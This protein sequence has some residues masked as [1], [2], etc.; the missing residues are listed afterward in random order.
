MSSTYGNLFRISTFGESHGKA[1]G[2]VVDG[3]PAG[4]KL[5]EADIQAE[6]DRRKPGQSKLTTP[7]KEADTVEILSG[8][9][10]GR[11]TGTPIGMTV[12]NTDQRSH[13]YGDMV[14][15]YR[16]SHADFTY[17]LKYGFRDYRGGGRASARE[18]IGRVAAGAIARKI[19]KEVC[20]TEILA[21]VSQVGSIDADIDP[22]KATFKTIESNLVRC[23]DP[24]AA[25]KMAK[26]IDDAR[27]A[28]DS[29]GGVIQLVI[30]NAPKGVGEPVF[31]RAEA[32]LARAFLSLPA[33]KGFEIGSGFAGTRLRGSEHNDPFVNK[34]GTKTGT[35]AGKSKSAASGFAAIGTETNR[36]GGVQGG[37]T[38]GEPILCRIA[39][40][41]TATISMPQK[42]VDKQGK[43]RTLAAKGRHDPCVL[44]RAVVIVEAMAALTLVDLFLEQRARSGLFT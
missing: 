41:P 29:L 9:F 33:T 2:V 39:F 32:E 34:S 35:K 3:C 37:I 15:L 26:A 5:T 7:R 18:T 23:A 6:L 27:K 16:P 31:H 36:S 14:E 19:L 11:T 28:Q 42:T 22:L 1:V 21:Y 8:L 38:N 40:K 43:E 12:P 30:K 20:G 24:V 10:E 13:D 25:E 17:D 4:L 44:P